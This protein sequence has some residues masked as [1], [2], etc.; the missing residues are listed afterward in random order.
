MELKI[1]LTA[2]TMQ[3]GALPDEGLIFDSLFARQKFNPSPNKVSSVFFD[4]ASLIIHGE[5]FIRCNTHAD[6]LL[7]LFQT[8]HRDFSI[9]Q[10]SSYLD[11]SILYGDVQEE[12][13]HMRTF[14]DGRIKPDCFS[15]SRLLAFPPACGVMLIMLN[16]YDSV[17]FGRR[18]ILILCRF[19]NHAVEQLAAVNE[20]GRFT[21]PSPNLPTER[22]EAA[23]RKHDNDL[24]QTGRL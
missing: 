9:S 21:R 12:Q 1:T 4:W 8:N 3:P 7:D 19:H 18:K 6:P 13:N 23:W 2:L 16:R 22:A 15:E 20:N 5:S 24:F 11:L 14:K 10:T 17:N